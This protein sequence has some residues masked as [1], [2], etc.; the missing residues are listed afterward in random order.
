M[1]AWMVTKVDEHEMST[2]ARMSQKLDRPKRTNAVVIAQVK[3]I[4]EQA[5][6]RAKERIQKAATT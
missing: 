4:R 3:R 5:V 6:L 2:I 1:G